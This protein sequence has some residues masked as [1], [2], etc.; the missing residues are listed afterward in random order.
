MNSLMNNTNRQVSEMPLSN[1]RK[2]ECIVE[3]PAGPGPFPAQVM[4]PGLRYDMHRP[5]ISLPS[6]YLLE[7]GFAVC[8]FNWAFYVEDAT[9]VCQRSCRVISCYKH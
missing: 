5:T 6:H 2:L 1:E 3:F 7:R 4:L 9:G 8:R